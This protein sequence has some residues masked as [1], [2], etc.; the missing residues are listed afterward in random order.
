MEFVHFSVLQIFLLILSFYFVVGNIKNGCIE[1]SLEAREEEARIVVTATV[2]NL[3][4]DTKHPGMV[5][6]EVEIKRVFK[7]G[8]ILN[9]FIKPTRN[10]IRHR[11]LHQRIQVEG[12]RDPK[13]CDSDIRRI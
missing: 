9:N 13:I 10:R 12:F 1:K 7:G 5:M 11:R 2:K 8:A 4:L 6:G 3:M